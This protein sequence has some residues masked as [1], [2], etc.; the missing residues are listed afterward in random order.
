MHAEHQKLKWIVVILIGAFVASGCGGSGDMDLQR[1]ST[2]ELDRMIK[3]GN[4]RERHSAVAEFN[5]SWRHR[6]A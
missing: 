4:A 6:P 1:A 5:R 3:S 2:K